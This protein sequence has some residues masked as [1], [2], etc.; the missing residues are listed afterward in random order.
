MIS[1]ANK[2]DQQEIRELSLDELDD[3][4]GAGLKS[5]LIKVVK[6]IKDLFD[7]PGDLRRP[8]DRPN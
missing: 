5:F 7:G 2:G 4:N 3:V 8:T 1:D 6:T